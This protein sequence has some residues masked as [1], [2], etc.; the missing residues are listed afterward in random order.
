[1]Y[2]KLTSRAEDIYMTLSTKLNCAYLC[3]PSSA[4]G[5]VK[6][7]WK[8]RL[9]RV[10]DDRT[11]TLSPSCGLYPD[12]GLVSGTGWKTASLFSYMARK[13]RWGGIWIATLLE[14]K[15][16]FFL[17]TL[18]S[19]NSLS[20]LQQHQLSWNRATGI[21]GTPSLHWPWANC[22]LKSALSYMPQRQGQAASL[23]RAPI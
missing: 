18:A 2:L 4:V 22:P 3:F 15:S 5:T 1:M 16:Q 6:G 13:E 7:W 17:L 21:N 11:S 23:A 20:V 14:Q 9:C 19:P 8:S 10:R 12:K